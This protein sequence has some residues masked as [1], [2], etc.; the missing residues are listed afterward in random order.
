MDHQ[1]LEQHRRILGILFIASNAL[2]L[3]GAVVVGLFFG[4]AS[5]LMAGAHNDTGEAVAA[6]ALLALGLG[7]CLV[8][9][10]VPGLITGWGLLKRRPWSRMASLV[11]GI[12]ALPSVPL[13][14]ALGIYA[15]WFFGQQGSERVFE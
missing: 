6:T 5:L 8:L 13:G 2:T 15:I 3:L 11:L 7:G 12:L 9:F 14:T 1:G 4:G 10:A